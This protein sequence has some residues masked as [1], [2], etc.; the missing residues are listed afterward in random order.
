MTAQLISFDAERASNYI[1]NALAMFIDDPADSDHQRGYLAALL[2]IYR[3]GLGRGKG[4]DRLAI[5]DAQIMETP[6][7]R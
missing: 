2:T 3:E 7:A 6:N 5:L 4:D 1:A